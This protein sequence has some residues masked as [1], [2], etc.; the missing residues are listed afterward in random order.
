VKNKF[1]SKE[2]NGAP[3]NKHNCNQIKQIPAHMR[4]EFKLSYFYQKYA[5]AYGIPV[6]G[7]SKV[8]S[9]G[10]RRACYVLRFFLANDENLKEIFYKRY[11]RLVV[12]ANNEDLFT[13]SEYNSLPVS[14]KPL[15]GLSATT[16]IPLITVAEENVQC[17]N[18]K[19]K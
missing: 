15:R 5:E 16:Q 10:L 17:S 13:V 3:T 2:R 18:D 7:S 19:S 14:F 9:S 6:L 1:A 12:L 8:S 4:S 11:L